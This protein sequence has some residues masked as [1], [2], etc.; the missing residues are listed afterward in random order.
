MNSETGVAESERKK[1]TI[2]HQ[3]RHQL[4]IFRRTSKE[5]VVQA[6]DELNPT[7]TNVV[8]TEKAVADAK[9]SK[10]SRKKN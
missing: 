3:R 5:K 4:E 9:E 1:W 6:V 2:P 8:N 7:N 10:S